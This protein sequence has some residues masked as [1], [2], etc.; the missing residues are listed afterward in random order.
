[1]SEVSPIKDPGALKDFAPDDVAVLG[2]HRR[3][4]GEMTFQDAVANGG[5]VIT[6]AQ[7]LSG[8]GGVKWTDLTD[9]PGTILA[10]QA[11]F[12]NSGGTDLEFRGVSYQNLL[13]TEPPVTGVVNPGH[14][15]MSIASA[16]EVGFAAGDIAIANRINS[17]DV[18]EQ[19]ATQSGA[20]TITPTN[21]ANRSS[22][23]TASD[24]GF[25]GTI[26]IKE[27]AAHPTVA[28]LRKEALLGISLHSGGNVVAILNSPDPYRDQG[29]AVNDLWRPS[30]SGGLDVQAGTGVAT[31]KAATLRIQTSEMIIEG[32]GLGFHST[33]G[34]D[35]NHSPPIAA[36]NPFSFATIESNGDVFNLAVLDFP[37]TWNNAGTETALTGNRAVVHQVAWLANGEGIVQL[38]IKNYN[39][40]DTAVAAITSERILNPLWDIA[41]EFGA[42]IGIVVISNN[43]TTTW[44]DGIAHLFPMQGGQ[45]STG[46]ITQYVGLTD[47]PT[48][49]AG[50]AG[51]I[52]FVNA[53]EDADNYGKQRTKV[54]FQFPGNVP[55]APLTDIALPET[56]NARAFHIDSVRLTVKVADGVTDLIIDVNVD[57]TTIFPGAKPTLA[58]ASLTSSTAISPD[59][60]GVKGDSIKIDLDQGGTVWEDLTVALEGWSEPE[61]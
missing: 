33:A 47:T 44:D 51:R 32:R 30:D 6:L 4:S 21:L 60:I 8:V 26:V 46:G 17:R 16:T 49:R 58:A 14:L 40:Y 24:A 36:Q 2:G 55:G 19:I 35:P 54:T 7:L 27:Y 28:D 18:Q 20:A 41:R 50:K 22:F 57:G 52:P 13:A 34:I 48:D 56:I 39:D 42:S 3:M 12:G 11:V 53:S 37:K 29:Q 15:E 31:E 23:W 38:G 1:M 25:T 5:A 45:V 43:A 59:A 9:T 10:D 61:L